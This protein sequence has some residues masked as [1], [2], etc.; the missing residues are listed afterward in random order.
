VVN[1]TE[2]DHAVEHTESKKDSPFTGE[3]WFGMERI[4][5]GNMPDG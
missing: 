5:P 2:P 4:I 1:V 3:G